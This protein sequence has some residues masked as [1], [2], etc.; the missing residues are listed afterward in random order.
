MIT[1][2]RFPRFYALTQTDLGDALAALG[3]R[4]PGTARLEEAVAAYDAAIAILDRVP[5][6][7][8]GGIARAGRVRASELLEQRRVSR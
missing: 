1:R 5:A 8:Y 3:G 2:G 4:E 7:R 6:D